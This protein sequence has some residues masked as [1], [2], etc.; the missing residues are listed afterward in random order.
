M[1]TFTEPRTYAEALAVL[2]ARRNGANVPEGY[3]LAALELTGDYTRTSPTEVL[4]FATLRE[5]H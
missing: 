2:N 5:V 3:I 1:N 4:E